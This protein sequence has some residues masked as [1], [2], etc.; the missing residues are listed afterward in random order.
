MWMDYVLVLIGI[1]L[2]PSVETVPVRGKQMFVDHKNIV[3]A[4]H[5]LIDHLDLDD[6]EKFRRSGREFLNLKASSGNVSMTVL[7]K[8]DMSYIAH[9]NESTLFQ[10]LDCDINGRLFIAEIAAMLS[11][12]VD[13]Y[14]ER[15][16]AESQEIF[17]Q[18]I[19][20]FY[21]ADNADSAGGLE[22]LAV[23]TAVDERDGHTWPNRRQEFSAADADGDGR[24]NFVEFAGFLFP[25][26]GSHVR[27]RHAQRFMQNFVLSSP[28][29]AGNTLWIRCTHNMPVGV[30]S[31]TCPPRA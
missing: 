3:M 23:L 4:L 6:F 8:D 30:E 20:T 11:A 18:A 19:T 17:N 31:S 28:L 12:S 1:V 29:I 22:W 14:V 26:L 27:T 13:V 9:L 25:E 2:F 21:G 24:L 7:G 15:S 5:G 16:T 10:V